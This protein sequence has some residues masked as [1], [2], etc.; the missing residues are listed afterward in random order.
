[1]K[2]NSTELIYI[3]DRSGSMAGLE[4]DTIGGYNA[5]LEKQK[6][7]K[8]EARVTTVLFDHDYELLHDRL[9]LEEV[10]PITGKDYSVRGTTALLDALG[11]TIDDQIA[12]RKKEAREGRNPSKV[13][14]VIMTDGFENASRRFSAEEVRKRISTQRERYGWEFLFLGANI[15]AITF[16][17]DYGIPED[18]AVSFR[19]DSKGLRLNYD[20][21]ADVACCY[22]SRRVIDKEWSRGIRMWKDAEEEE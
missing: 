9:P 21:V 6:Q 5:Y 14:F 20:A 7:Q 10:G 13:L 22:R 11:R 18:R 19:A 8:G 16:A 15:D 1:M 3:L 2:T 17:A 12:R 4:E